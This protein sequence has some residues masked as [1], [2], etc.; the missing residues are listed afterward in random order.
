LQL[1]VSVATH[2]SMLERDN[3]QCSEKAIEHANRIRKNNCGFSSQNS[4]SAC[5]LVKLLKILTLQQ[6]ASNVQDGSKGYWGDMKQIPR[7]R[8]AG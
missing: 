4:L 7:L 6:S 3:K 5:T 2:P 1:A 8:S